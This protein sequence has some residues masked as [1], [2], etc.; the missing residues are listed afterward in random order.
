MMRVSGEH[1]LLFWGSNVLG[2]LLYKR[3][4][5]RINWLHNRGQLAAERLRTSVRPARRRG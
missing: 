4:T 3:N 1:V 5:T 2:A